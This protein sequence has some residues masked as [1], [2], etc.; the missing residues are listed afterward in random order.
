MLLFGGK[1]IWSAL[2][3][4]VFLWHELFIMSKCFHLT[5]LSLI[6]LSQS[7][8]CW[9]AAARGQPLGV[10]AGRQGLCPSQQPGERGRYSGEWLEVVWYWRCVGEKMVA[11]SMNFVVFVL[12]TDCFCFCCF[13]MAKL[14]LSQFRMFLSRALVEASNA[15]DF[16]GSDT[17][18]GP[19]LK[20]CDDDAML[21][22]FPMIS[23][24]FSV[25]LCCLNTWPTSQPRLGCCISH[26][27]LVHCSALHV[28]HLLILHLSFSHS[29]QN[30]NKQFI[31][32]DFSKS[33]Q[34][35]DKLTPER[36]EQAAEHDM[37]LCMKV[38]GG[39]NF[40]FMPKVFCAVYFCCCLLGWTVDSPIPV[41]EKKECD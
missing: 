23:T 30:M 34:S 1:T 21:H 11:W 4:A 10:P 16:V 14:F 38:S 13:Q 41:V 35:V 7:A 19:L 18:I 33:T 22:M 29:C 36:V 28:S 32:N 39:C 8:L 26:V 37:P 17:R 2:R 9:G 40:E 12:F 20:V 31:G 27:I 5:V 15:F 24:C 3:F 25:W 6:S